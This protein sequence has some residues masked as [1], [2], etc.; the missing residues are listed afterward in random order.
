MQAGVDGRVSLVCII[1]D[2][3]RPKSDT[4]RNQKTQSP[5]N[6]TQQQCGGSRGSY[7]IVDWNLSQPPRKIP[8]GLLE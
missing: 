6:W 4:F 8:R 1:K 2:L 7:T 3:G 5:W